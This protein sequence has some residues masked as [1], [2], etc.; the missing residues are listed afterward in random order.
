M[1]TDMTKETILAFVNDNLQRA[2]VETDVNTAILTVIT[3]LNR[4]ELLEGE[5]TGTILQGVNSLAKPTGYKSYISLQ[6]TASGAVSLPLKP[7][8]GGM[9]GIEKLRSNFEAGVITGPPYVYAA[10]GTKIEFHTAADKDYTYTFKYYRKNPRDVDQL[11]FSD[12]WENVFNFGATYYTALK[13]KMTAQAAMWQPVY[14]TERQLMILSIP[15]QPRI[16]GG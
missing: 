6:L 16:A 7:A 13:R 3:E 15:K 10:Y 9:R 12:D 1:S 5:D 8:S 2:E 4:Y 11:L 14:I